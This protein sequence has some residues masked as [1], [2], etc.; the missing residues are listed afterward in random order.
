MYTYYILHTRMKSKC[1]RLPS[2]YSISL[3]CHFPHKNIGKDVR[4]IQNYIIFWQFRY[5]W[6]TQISYSMWNFD[7]GTGTVKTVQ[8]QVTNWIDVAIP[9]IWQTTA[10]PADSAAE[11]KHLKQNLYPRECSSSRSNKLPFLLL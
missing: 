7:I 2:G 9:N 3:L 8:I 6:T 5:Y 4:N 10:V 1:K 11:Q